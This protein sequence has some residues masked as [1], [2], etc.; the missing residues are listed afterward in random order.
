[1]TGTTVEILFDYLKSGNLKAF[2]NYIDLKQHA[3]ESKDN[4]T[5][6]QYACKQNQTEAVAHL[7]RNQANPN[8]A[9]TETEKPIEIAATKGYHQIFQLLVESDNIEIPPNVLCILLKNI[10]QED[11]ED[12]SYKKCYQSVISKMKNM[13]TA[14]PDGLVNSALHYAIINEEPEDVLKLLDLGVYLASKN[15]LDLSPIEYIRDDLLE[16]HLDNC[17]RTD[18]EIFEMS[19]SSKVYFDYR[20]LVPPPKSNINRNFSFLEVPEIISNNKTLEF[21]GT[22]D[23]TA[24]ME[25]IYYIRLSRKLKPLLKHPVVSSFLFMK[26]HRIMCLWRAKLAI[27]ILFSTLLITYILLFYKGRSDKETEIKY[28][29][30]IFLMILM[31]CAVMKIVHLLIHALVYPKKQIITI[32]NVV[33]LCLILITFSILFTRSH[34][35]DTR[36]VLSSITV[37][38]S[39]FEL[40]LTFGQHPKLSRNIVMFQIVASNF[41]KVLLWLSF[42]ILAFAF[43][44]YVLSNE[45]PKIPIADTNKS[46]IGDYGLQVFETILMF[47]GKLDTNSLNFESFPVIGR[48]IFLVFAFMMAIVAFNLLNAVAVRD[49]QK[50]QGDAELEGLIIQVDRIHCLESMVFG[51]FL[52]FRNNKFF[53]MFYCCN[54]IA[55]YFVN[56][57]SLFPYYLQE[58]NLCFYPWRNGIIDLEYVNNNNNETASVHKLRTCCYPCRLKLDGTIVKDTMRRLYNRKSVKPKQ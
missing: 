20:T 22:S 18:N 49:V 28:V 39:T 58:Y 24:E 25:V 35:E 23:C 21:D 6:L 10:A 26:W 8:L 51:A 50:L 17:I 5:L 30:P 42:V 38:L 1:M 15:N 32:E 37:L 55:C 41:L 19:N 36:K 52:I 4:I 27:C 34:C 56:R 3:N 57:I 44:F 53:K 7:L 40:V 9:N 45:N 48:L 31:F 12:V 16:R 29:I 11:L 46:F 14:L 54:S 43:S 47:T 2:V 33:E 13:K